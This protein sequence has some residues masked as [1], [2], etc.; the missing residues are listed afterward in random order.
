MK[1]FL[2]SHKPSL[3]ALGIS[4]LLAVILLTVAALTESEIITSALKINVLVTG[5]ISTWLIIKAILHLG[6]WPLIRFSLFA[7]GIAL[8]IFSGYYLMAATIALFY[9]M[10]TLYWRFQRNVAAMSSPS[11]YEETMRWYWINEYLHKRPSYRPF[12]KK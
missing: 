9:L 2:K 8:G 11:T 10:V 3:L 5:A 12:G 4:L 7:L 1:V 6:K